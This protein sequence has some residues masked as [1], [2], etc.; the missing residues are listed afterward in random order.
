MLGLVMSSRERGERCDEQAGIEERGDGGAKTT[1]QQGFVARSGKDGVY[2]VG[3]STARRAIKAEREGG[4]ET[5]LWVSDTNPGASP[6]RQCDRVRTEGVE[7]GV[8]GQSV[9]GPGAAAP[10]W[11]SQ[12][13]GS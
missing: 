5:G 1:G 13:H 7:L 8:Q 3:S 2:H 4:R 10:A 12:L 9:G 6:W 11:C